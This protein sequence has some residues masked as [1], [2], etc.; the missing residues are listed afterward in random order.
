MS[1]LI[2]N[3]VNQTANRGLLTNMGNQAAHLG[4]NIS[5]LVIQQKTA[6]RE[7]I[8][9]AKYKEV[10][11]QFYETGD[12][13]L[14]PQLQ[15]LYPEKY[16]AT[17]KT[18]NDMDEISRKAKVKENMNVIGYLSANM[19]EKAAE[20]L[21]VMSRAYRNN[22]DEGDADKLQEMSRAVLNGDAKDI[23]R[24]LEVITGAIPE[25]KS[26]LEALNS[27]VG[28]DIAENEF[29]IKVME[30]GA[31]LEWDQE[32]IDAAKVAATQDEEYG[33]TIS[34]VLNYADALE[35]GRDFDQNE[36]NSNI[37]DLRKEWMKYTE[38]YQK[39]TT[40]YDKV[41]AS[42]S[43]AL[44]M[45]ATE[46]AGLADLAGLTAF[47][48]M[49]DDG[50]VRAEDVN[51]IKGANSFLETIN[52]TVAGWKDGDILGDDQRREMIRLAK[53][54]RMAQKKYV[55]E[56]AFPPLEAAYN[57]LA[58]DNGMDDEGKV[59]T[60]IF[61]DY[62]SPNTPNEEKSFW[63]VGNVNNNKQST[64][65]QTAK[66]FFAKE[67]Q[68]SIDAGNGIWSKAELDEINDQSTTLEDLSKW[69]NTWNK[70]N[71]LGSGSG[72]APENFNLDES[73]TL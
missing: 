50:I 41:N 24:S 43:S 42:I 48:R 69:K 34:S 71:A 5:N 58:K 63:S 3:F 14:I 55:D 31:K 28:S 1:D 11:D 19:P 60:E 30:S 35:G 20:E 4:G 6:E 29:A 47:Q 25:G 46:Q 36:F 56:L 12:T 8:K 49:I 59:Y 7:R 70:Y 67:A 61:G 45:G 66:A 17:I 38:G 26:A 62:N 9:A 32:T 33:K 23:Q 27:A 37:T 73:E 40:S 13:S 54:Y 72:E 65:L 10:A 51:N 44:E 18:W 15:E 2:Q 22:G 39:A 57:R 53:E 16:E 68:A 52:V 64:E 21:S